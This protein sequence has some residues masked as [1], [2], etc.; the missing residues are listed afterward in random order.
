MIRIVGASLIGALSD[1]RTG[2]G[3]WESVSGV[4][5]KKGD[6]NDDVDFD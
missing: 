5:G 4:G 3:T 2:F 1:A 6:D